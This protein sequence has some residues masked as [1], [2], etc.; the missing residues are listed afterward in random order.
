MGS[1]E[2]S[3]G[4]HVSVKQLQE[5]LLNH[6]PLRKA[7]RLHVI[8]CQQCRDRLIEAW[9]RSLRAARHVKEKPTTEGTES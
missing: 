6:K 2:E 5:L 4:P 3:A 7:Q 9:I 8:G 1:E